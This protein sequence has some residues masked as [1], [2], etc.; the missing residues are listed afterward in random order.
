MATTTISQATSAVETR[1][2]SGA[3]AVVLA[4]ATLWWREIVHFYRSIFRVIGVIASP[5]LFWVVLGSGFGKHYM[6][7]LFAGTV[8]MIVLFTAIFSMMSVIEDRREG[9]LQSVMVAPVH[10]SAIVLGKVLGG[11]T[12][13]AIQGLIFVPFGLLIGVHFSLVQVLLIVVIV[14]LFGFSLTALGFIIAWPMDSTQGFHAIINMLFIPLWLLS[15]SVFSTTQSMRWMGWVMRVNPL[16]YGT[17]ALRSLLFPAGEAPTLPINMC[18]AIM[19][20]FTVVMF[21]FAFLVANRRT[22]KPAA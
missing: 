9:F 18:I 3:S 6:D 12:L 2:A 16:T 4:A 15:G 19:A 14:F 7:F 20:A 13:A 10:R 11:A 5:I 17:E 22:T 1:A 21:F 8:T